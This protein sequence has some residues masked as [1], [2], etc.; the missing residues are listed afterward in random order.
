MLTK[1]PRPSTLRKYLE[2]KHKDKRKE[3]HTEIEKDKYRTWHPEQMS[4]ATYAK[5]NRPGSTLGPYTSQPTQ[6]ECQW[7][8]ELQQHV[9]G[10]ND[11]K[12]LI[13]DKKQEID[14][15][16][17]KITEIDQKLRTLGSLRRE[18]NRCRYRRSYIPGTGYSSEGEDMM[19]RWQ[20]IQEEAKEL[21]AQRKIICQ[22]WRVLDREDKRLQEQIPGHQKN[23]RYLMQQLGLVVL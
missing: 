11:L 14:K 22:E 15:C 7:L 17:A 16:R 5:Q 2:R 23:I 1:T 18:I 19:S 3:R 13:P 4:F 9:A 12:S 6:Q 20:Q 10:L 21:F 8:I